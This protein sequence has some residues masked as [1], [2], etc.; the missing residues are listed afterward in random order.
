VATVR[1]NLK[2]HLR[3]SEAGSDWICSTGF[4]VVRCREKVAASEFIFAHFFAS[5][6][7]RQVEALLTGSN[8][9]AINSGDVKALRI[10]IPEID[11]QI[12]IGLV[13]SDMDIEI[14]AIETKVAK[15]RLLKQGM[16]QDLLTGRIRLV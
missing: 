11:E 3:F 8:Y 13:L 10:P 16:M 2:S 7:D 4:C 9:P 15:A 12:A 5:T 14:A 6:I 1:P